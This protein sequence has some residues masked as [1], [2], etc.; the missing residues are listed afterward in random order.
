MGQDRCRLLLVDDEIDILDS[1]RRL[2][3]RDY[4]VVAAGGGRAAF[5]VLGNVRIDLIICDQ[6]MP[7]ITGDQVLAAAR[8]CQP[9]AVR[10]LLTGYSDMETLVKCVNEAGLYRYVTKPWEPTAFRQ[11]VAKALEDLQHDRMLKGMLQSPEEFIA[12]CDREHNL[13]KQ[14]GHEILMASNLKIRNN[15]LRKI[16]RIYTMYFKFHFE[17]EERFMLSIRYPGY[18]VH[19]HF[20]RQFM[21]ALERLKAAFG[22]G[23]DVYGEVKELYKKLTVHHISDTDMEMI[24]YVREMHAPSPLAEKLTAYQAP[25]RSND[26][27]R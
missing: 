16:L 25:S 9:E 20:H 17:N 24:R 8:E 19:R 27:S 26:P 4:E 18:D 14:L 12:Q 10:I 13:I 15:T 22:R 21:E 7:D 3:H 2:F 6:R 5:D 11:M 1:L 23:E